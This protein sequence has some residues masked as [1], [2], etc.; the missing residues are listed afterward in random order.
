MHTAAARGPAPGALPIRDAAYYR[1]LLERSRRTIVAGFG[2]P[3]LTPEHLTS[4][5]A[6]VDRSET[7]LDRWP[8]VERLCAAMPATLVH[9]DF[10]AKNVRVRDGARGRTLLAF[11]W[12]TAGWG[13]AGIDLRGIDLDEYAREVLH[14]WP[15]LGRSDMT[16]FARMGRILWFTACVDW[17]MWAIDTAWVWR[18][19]NTMPFY[20]RDLSAV[21]AELGWT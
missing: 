19:M 10:R 20:E 4:L 14:A 17:E 11:D 9:A 16:T 8:E 15:A 12:E 13:L 5:R 18:L 21:M 7:L 1:Q 3:A 2:N 6:V